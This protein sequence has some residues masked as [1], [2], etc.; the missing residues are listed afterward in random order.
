MGDLTVW[1]WFT[2][3]AIFIL[4]ML[5][6]LAVWRSLTNP[7]HRVRFDEALAAIQRGEVEGDVDTALTKSGEKKPFKWFPYWAEATA[8][9]GA[10]VKDPKAPGRT[11][12]GVAIACA[13]LGWV[14]AQ[15]LGLLAG[16]VAGPIL[17]KAWLGFQATKRVTA[18]ERQLPDLLS[19]M[20]ASLQAGETPQQALVSAAEGFPAPLGDEL[21]TM[22][23]NMDVNVQLD[24]ALNQLS[25]RV[26]SRE[27]QFLTSSI[28]IAVRSGADLGPQIETIQ[29]IVVQRTRIR[30]TLRAAVAKANSTAYLAYAAVPLM[31]FVSTRTED[32][33]EFFFATTLGMVVLIAMIAL[34]ALGVFFIHQIVKGVETT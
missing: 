15:T 9:S 16:A 5:L 28:I 30:Q 33:R 20:R 11:A 1:V 34:Y 22:K 32:N 26:K 12:I 25:G 29:Q 14:G 7:V 10:K 6:T 13:G 8:M 2:V 18:M 3:G 27:M 31:F 4:A 23:R 21:N 24:T 19:A 17:M